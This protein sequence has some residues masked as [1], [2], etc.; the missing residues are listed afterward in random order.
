MAEPQAVPVVSSGNHILTNLL[1]HSSFDNTGQVSG[2]NCTVS[3]DSTIKKYGNY[4][5]KVISTA[6]SATENLFYSSSLPYQTKG[7][8]YYCRCEMYQTV[9]GA[10]SG[11]QAYW[12]EAE[13]VMGTSTYD[14]TKISTW[15]IQSFRIVRSSWT[16]GNQ[17]FR[18]DVENMKSP[19]FVYI[20]GAMLIDLTSAYGSGNEPT[21]AWCDA[22]IPYFS[23]TLVVG[24]LSPGDVI[25]FDY[26]GAG[27][28][29]E[30][31]AGKYKLETWG[32]QGGNYS[33][34]KGGYGGYSA[35]VLSLAKKTPLYVY[36]GEQGSSSAITGGFNGGGSG[37]TN[38]RGGGGGTDIRVGQDSLYSRVIVAG[39]GGGSGVANVSG[40]G[41]GGGTTGLG[42]YTNETTL[43][44]SNRSG[45]GGA[46]S[47]GGISWNNVASTKGS[48]GQGGNASGYSCG[49][50]GGGW[51]G[52]GGAYDNDSDSD[53]RNGGGGSG[54]IY[55]AATASNYP[56]GC[57]LNSSYYLSDAQT[58]TG[59]TSFLSP[60]GANETGHTGNGYARI[61]VIEV[62]PTFSAPVKISGSWKIASDGFVKING[63]W[64][65]VERG[66]TKIN[67]T[68]K[69]IS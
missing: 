32:A 16:S 15:Q 26:S 27:N 49:G 1:P 3:Y 52:G 48:F 35:G 63:T 38:G 2:V 55:T 43:A 44:G 39:G 68:Q 53:G 33:S 28:S 5:L 23:G 25:N 11:M 24:K 58:V 22:N 42:G 57:L 7:H 14:S 61:T 37:I 17:K 54:Y 40:K 41:V 66:F 65:S 62:S 60:A 45:G 47:Q 6:S 50:G 51:Y 31:P 69:E 59:A 12:P 20:D 9:A 67:G 10:S 8:I 64:K 29:I 13:P 46:Q 36:S 56:S 21:Q 34:Y 30:L 4:S 18:F 19:S